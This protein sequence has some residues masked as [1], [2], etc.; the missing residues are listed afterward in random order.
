MNLKLLT[1]L[2]NEE[3]KVKEKVRASETWVTITKS[4]MHITGVLKKKEEIIG[5]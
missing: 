2:K 3:E 5:T 4:L 1:N